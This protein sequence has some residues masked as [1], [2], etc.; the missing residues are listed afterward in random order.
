MQED[1]AFD[2]PGQAFRWNRYAL[3]SLA[4]VLLFLF[5]GAFLWI[6]PLAG[7]LLGFLAYIRAR[8]FERLG[9]IK[10]YFWLRGL[11]FGIAGLSG[12]MLLFQLIAATR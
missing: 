11:S 6:H 7:A 9:A 8:R 1:L 5:L 10:L 12:F 4:W 3:I 2:S